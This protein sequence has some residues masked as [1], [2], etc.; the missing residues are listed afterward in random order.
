M[1]QNQRHGPSAKNTR[2]YGVRVA[3]VDVVVSRVLLDL[4][5]QGADVTFRAFKNLRKAVLVFVKH[6]RTGHA[7]SVVVAPSYLQDLGE[8]LISSIRPWRQ[9]AA[10]S[11]DQ[12]KRCL[13]TSLDGHFG[14]I[15]FAAH[16]GYLSFSDR[17]KY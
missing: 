8:S 4:F 1:F 6:Q 11:I 7:S 13:D 3:N 15:G 16:A 12:S 2:I 5:E 9:Q 17:V 10:T 14:G